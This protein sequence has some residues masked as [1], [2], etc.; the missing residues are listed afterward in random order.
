M[1]WIPLMA[2][3]LIHPVKWA[4]CLRRSI[5]ALAAESVCRGPFRAEAA[6]IHTHKTGEA[7]LVPIQAADI[8]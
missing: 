2:V 6:Y 7:H 8:K 1:T 3:G 5:V 4:P